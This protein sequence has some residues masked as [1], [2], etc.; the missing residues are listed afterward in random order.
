MKAHSDK[1][2]EPMKRDLQRIHAGQLF[3]HVMTLKALERRGLVRYVKTHQRYKLTADGQRKLK[4][5]GK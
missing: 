1:L 3:D 5:L 4:E 2:S